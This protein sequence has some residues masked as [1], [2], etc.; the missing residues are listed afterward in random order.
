MYLSFGAL[1][2]HGGVPFYEDMGR[3]FNSLVSTLTKAKNSQLEFASKIYPDHTHT[4]IL[5]PA[6]SDALLY[7]YGPHLP[8]D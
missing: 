4:T 8:R 1:E 6:L 7:L 2:A 5:A 3:N